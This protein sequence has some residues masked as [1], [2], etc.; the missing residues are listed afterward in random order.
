MQWSSDDP[1]IATVDNMGLVTAVSEG[2]TKVYA[3]NSDGFE[4][5]INIRVMQGADEQRLTVHLTVGQKA[6]LYL[7]EDTSAI[8]WES[9]APEIVSVDNQGQ[10]TGVSK[11]M[12]LV[13]ATYNGETHQIYVRVA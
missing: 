10:I 2:L 12:T 11:G 7:N 1:A 5:Y 8:A 9:L 4:E 3:R 6:N 13:N